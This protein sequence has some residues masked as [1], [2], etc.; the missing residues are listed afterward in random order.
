MTLK[1]G[2]SLTYMCSYTTNPCNIAEWA[3]AVN[4]ASSQ[5]SGRSGGWMEPGTF[6]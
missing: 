4:W 3:D 2:T 1:K 5:C 6:G